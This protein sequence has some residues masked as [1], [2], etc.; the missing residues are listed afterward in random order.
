[1]DTLI[2]FIETLLISIESET[3]CSFS[4]GRVEGLY[5]NVDSYQTIEMLCLSA[6]RLSGVSH[7]DDQV[8]VALSIC[9]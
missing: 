5:K 4:N 1:M 3:T 2:A 6:A 7:R 8:R 9:K